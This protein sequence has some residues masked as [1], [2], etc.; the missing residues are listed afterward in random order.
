MPV[1]Q[2][3]QLRE[4]SE[5]AFALLGQ[6][7]NNNFRCR[8]ELSTS[9]D[10]SN[11]T[12]ITDSTVS[13]TG[14][15]NVWEADFSST[16]TPTEMGRTYY[17]R[18]RLESSD[19]N[20]V[21]G[22]VGAQ[23][24]FQTEAPVITLEAPGRLP[25]PTV[26]R[27]TD[28]L[29]SLSVGTAATGGRPSVWRWRVSPNSTITNSDPTY[30]SDGPSIVIEGLEG[31]TDYWIDVRA[32]NAT[33]NSAYSPVLE[34]S[35]MVTVIPAPG[36]PDRPTISQTTQTTITASTKAASSGATTNGYDW[37]LIDASDSSVV[38]TQSTE[39]PSVKFENLDPDT[40]YL[41]SV[42]ARGVG[43][44]S[45]YSQARAVDTEAVPVVPKTP[46]VPGQPSVD[47]NVASSTSETTTVTVSTEPAS[48]GGDPGLAPDKYEW[49]LYREGVFVSETE[50]DAPTI[51]WTDLDQETTYS[52]RVRA[53]N[54]AGTSALST[55]REFET[56]FAIITRAMAPPTPTVAVATADIDEDQFIA[57]ATGGSGGGPTEFWEFTVL[58]GSTII[59]GPTE[60]AG[61][62]F[63]ARG[64]TAETAYT[65]RVRAGNGTRTGRKYSAAV[66]AT[67]TTDPPAVVIPP[68][69]ITRSAGR[70]TVRLIVPA[71]APSG[72]YGSQNWDPIFRRWGPTIFNVTTHTTGTA[73][74][75]RINATREGAYNR[76]FS[77]RL[78][79]NGDFGGVA[80]LGR[81]AGNHPPTSERDGG[82]L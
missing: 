35:T 61:T 26:V 63:T 3:V 8:F 73:T 74:T 14:Q 18:A 11:P 64:L 43:G 50:T 66:T 7:L 71:S 40:A 10:Y 49:F 9:A 56:A 28:E 69:P 34:T 54:T 57:R 19:G 59:A 21:S 60:Q 32:E 44:A 72:N 65:V 6:G 48:T 67:V 53:K 25:R 5:S 22:W 75:L 79:Y 33:G 36:T 45:A 24:T 78:T 23:R 52:T 68:V 2:E 37:R 27:R 4:E 31:G 12:V 1:P 55:A 82:P 76:D 17:V 15:T 20:L 77:W 13:I 62:A 51:T 39:T 70:N 47:S 80:W 46:G 29:I 16:I 30:T 38:A 41:L 42:R 81:R 58:R